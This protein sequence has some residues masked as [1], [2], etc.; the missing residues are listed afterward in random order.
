MNNQVEKIEWGKWER[1]HDQGDAVIIASGTMVDVALA[2]REG[3]RGERDIV[4]VNARFI[5]PMDKEMMEWVAADFDHVITLE[6]NSYM[7]GLGQTAGAYLSHSG[8]R[9]SFKSFAVPDRFIEHGSRSVL[10]KEIGLVPENIAEYIRSLY[11][12]R[13]AFLGRLMMRKNSGGKAELQTG[14]GQSKA[15][16]K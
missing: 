16:G 6:E 2:V 4:V 13:R 7:G 12:S 1:L 9:G 10:L 11:K 5:K 15:T 14:I 8:F 3:F